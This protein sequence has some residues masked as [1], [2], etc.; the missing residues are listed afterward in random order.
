[1]KCFS[2][3]AQYL[4]LS[5]FVGSLIILSIFAERLFY[6]IPVM[7]FGVIWSRIKCPKC[8]E[9]LLKDDKGWYIFTIRTTCRHCGQDTN[10]CE[11]EPDEVTQARLK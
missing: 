10:S 3:Y 2:A 11:V 8:G 5:M 7:V 4:L 9:P 1:M 6:I